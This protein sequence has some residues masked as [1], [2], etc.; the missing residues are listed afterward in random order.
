MKAGLR[1]YEDGKEKLI[2]QHNRTKNVAKRGLV[3]RGLVLRRDGNHVEKLP[4]TQLGCYYSYN[5][6]LTGRLVDIRQG[7][8]QPRPPANGRTLEPAALTQVSLALG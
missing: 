3:T 4:V 2:V 8:S 6:R 1:R 7:R 5:F